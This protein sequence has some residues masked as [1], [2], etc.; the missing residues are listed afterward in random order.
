MGDEQTDRQT[1]TDRQTDM[2]KLVGDFSSI[3]MRLKGCFVHGS[4]DIAVHLILLF[5]SK[6]HILFAVRTS[7]GGAECILMYGSPSTTQGARQLTLCCS[8]ACNNSANSCGF[9]CEVSYGCVT[10]HLA[11]NVL[12][13]TAQI[14]KT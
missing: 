1:E 7:R 5:C 3:R 12:T 9:K 4:L 14:F 2:T 6:V 10:E 8:L 13:V 11:Q